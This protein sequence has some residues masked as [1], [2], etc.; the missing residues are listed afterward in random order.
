MDSDFNEL[1]HSETSTAFPSFHP[2]Q[3]VGLPDAAQKYLAHAVKPGARIANAVHLHMHGEIKFRGDWCPFR[4]EEVIHR[5]RGFV[6]RAKIETKLLS[7]TASD[8]WIDGKGARRR[9]AFGWAPL[10]RANGADVSRSLLGRAQMEAMW[11]PT[12]LLAADA[13]WSALGVQMVNVRL[14][15]EDHPASLKLSVGA[16]GRLRTARIARWGDPLHRSEFKEHVFGAVVQEEKSFGG[17]SIPTSLRLGWTLEGGDFG[18]DGERLRV[19]VDAA[20]FK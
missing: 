12:S 6:W 7:V 15:L 16:D 17:I 3:L 10:L 8:Q 2:A 18:P 5:Q 19:I 4:A 13:R 14:R 20:E 11:N 1:W 9:D